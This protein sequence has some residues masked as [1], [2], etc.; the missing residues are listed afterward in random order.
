MGQADI[1]FEQVRSSGCLSYVVGCQKEKVCVVIDPEQDK[2]EE[3]LGL[4]ESFSS[5]LLYA[6]DTHTHADHVSACKILR[7]RG[8]AQV[9]MHRAA[10]APYVDLK[11]D[12]GDVIRFGAVEIRVLHTPGHTE[13]STCLLAGDRLF[14]GDTLLIGGCGRTDLPG[15]NPDKQYESLRKLAALADSIQIFPAHDYRPAFSTLG[16]EKKSNSRMLIGSREEF[17]Q[18]MSSRHPPL[19]RKF[20]L[21]LEHNRSPV[22]G[23]QRGFGEG[24]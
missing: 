7:E 2:I 10:D 11:V 21:A 9:V 18:F 23:T 8:D 20:Q 3:Y 19:P 22:Q 6:I 16:E 14:T 17:V 24:I 4:V 12:D 5:R 1:F 15:G 13:D